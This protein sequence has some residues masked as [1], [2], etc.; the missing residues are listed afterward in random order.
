MRVIKQFTVIGICYF[1]AYRIYSVK[2]STVKVS[3][4]V[5]KICG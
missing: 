2:P 3:E 5:G 4:F 1:S